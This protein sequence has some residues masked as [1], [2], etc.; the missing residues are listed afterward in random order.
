MGLAMT[1][2]LKRLLFY[3]GYVFV[4]W[5]S[6]RYFVRLPEV[7]EE[8]WFKPVIW[9]MPLLWWQ[10]SLGKKIK[11]FQGRWFSTLLY[12]LLGGLIY[13]VV[14]RLIVQTRFVFDFNRAGIA[15]VTAVVEE[16]TF[17]GFILSLLF[18]ETKQEEVSL[19]LSALGFALIHLPINVF[20]FHLSVPAL[21]GAFLLAFF[22]ALING[23][24]RLRSN[25]VLSSVIAHFVYLLLVLS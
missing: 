19:G 15:A 3:F 11:F 12:G 18:L 23:L 6:F 4:V 20:V 5:G 25:N 13:F 24:L 1:K 21:V 7:V 16:L 2:N 14:L 8:L 10:F 9:L 22:V 17:S